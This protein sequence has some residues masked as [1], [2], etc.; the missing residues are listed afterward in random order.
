MGWCPHKT[1]FHSKLNG[2]LI[3]FSKL[4]TSLQRK[5]YKEHEPCVDLKVWL[6]ECL[7]SPAGALLLA[8]LGKGCWGELSSVVGRAGCLPVGT[9]QLVSTPPP[10]PTALAQVPSASSDPAVPQGSCG[11]P[12]AFF[13]DCPSTPL[14]PPRNGLWTSLFFFPMYISLLKY[15]VTNICS[16]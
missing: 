13:P 1:A 2:R 16:L 9:R 7:L 8:G 14:L 6:Q 15:Y 5:N 11:S 10:L 4:L 12:R 3:D